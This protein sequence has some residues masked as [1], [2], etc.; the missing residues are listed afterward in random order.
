VQNVKVTAVGQRTTSAA[1]EPP[2]PG[3][4]FK[5]VTVL[6]S[7]ADAEAIELACST[8][9]PRLV[10]RGGRDQDIAETAGITLGELRGSSGRG[11]PFQVQPPVSENPT[12]TTNPVATTQR[13][14]DP[15]E[16]VAHRGPRRRVIQLIKGGVESTVTVM[17]GRPGDDTYSTTD[18]ADPFEGN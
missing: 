5:S 14:S 7:L 1:N 2:P 6:A 15:P 18:T 9:R 3:E 16:T 4:M 11:D 10:L 8:G 17:D 12:P 13:A